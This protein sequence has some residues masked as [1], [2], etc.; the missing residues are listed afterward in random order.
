MT[1]MV[2][3]YDVVRAMRE[4]LAAGVVDIVDDRVADNLMVRILLEVGAVAGEERGPLSYFQSIVEIRSKIIAQTVRETFELTM[5]VSER[6]SSFWMV[7]VFAI[8]KVEL[9]AC[10]SI[11]SHSYTPCRKNL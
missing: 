5:G 7:D 10:K 2:C 3:P 11:L 6:I 4:D 9:S 8:I 1:V